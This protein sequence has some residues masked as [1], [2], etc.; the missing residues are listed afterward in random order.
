MK[1]QIRWEQRRGPLDKHTVTSFDEG[2]ERDKSKQD[3][4]QPMVQILIIVSKL[5]LRLLENSTLFTSIYYFLQVSRM[6][7]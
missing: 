5:P 1:Q 4:V 3:W 2:R 7:T 6:S